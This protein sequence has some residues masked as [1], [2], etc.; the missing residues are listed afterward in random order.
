MKARYQEQDNSF[1]GFISFHLSPVTLNSGEHVTH[2]VISS[3]L[4]STAATTAVTTTAT[5]TTTATATLTNN[6]ITPM[7]APAANQCTP[8]RKGDD[9]EALLLNLVMDYSARKVNCDNQ[10][11]PVIQDN[12]IQKSL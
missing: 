6:S 3:N 2:S 4:P 9:L 8:V 5:T 12:H 7:L 1:P 11:K 10:N